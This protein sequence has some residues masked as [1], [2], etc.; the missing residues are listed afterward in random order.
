MANQF[1]IYYQTQPHTTF[2]MMANQLGE[3]TDELSG[4]AI[5]QFVSTVPYSY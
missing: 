3:L 2:H 1:L 4:K 5:T